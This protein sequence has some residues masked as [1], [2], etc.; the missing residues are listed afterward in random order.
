MQLKGPRFPKGLD[1]FAPIRSA[2]TLLCQHAEKRSSHAVPEAHRL[3]VEDLFSTHG[4]D[5][6]YHGLPM[7]P[8]K[9]DPD[10]ADDGRRLPV[11]RHLVSPGLVREQ[12]PLSAFQHRLL[13]PVLLELLGASIRKP[14]QSIEEHY[15]Y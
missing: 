3:V 2:T 7:P 14:E 6:G 9:T 15:R 5:L 12:H 11:R 13:P 1:R 8:Q 10:D 4:R